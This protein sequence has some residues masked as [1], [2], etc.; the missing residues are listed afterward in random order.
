MLFGGKGGGVV[1]RTRHT[2]K[3]IMAF[4]VCPACQSVLR[5][6]CTHAKT[7]PLRYTAQATLGCQ[8]ADRRHI[9]SLQTQRQI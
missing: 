2:A 1:A 7:E 4:V 8:L 9:H 3:L 6:H 5:G